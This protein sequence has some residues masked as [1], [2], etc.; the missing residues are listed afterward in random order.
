LIAPNA[1]KVA[2]SPGGERLPTSDVGWG[3]GERS[4]HLHS[5]GGEGNLC[6]TLR[7]PIGY[8]RILSDI[9]WLDLVGFTRIWPARRS[10][11]VSGPA[12]P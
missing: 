1:A 7:T 8:T 12:A 9:F 11:G 5:R 3:E 4:Q 10:L 2:P 6:P